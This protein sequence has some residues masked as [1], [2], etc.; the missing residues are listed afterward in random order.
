MA[1][2]EETA[3]VESLGDFIEEK[4][5]SEKIIPC[6]ISSDLALGGGIPF[7]CTI[8]VGGKQ[9]LG[10]TTWIL[11]AAANAQALYD[12]QI[13]YYNVEGRLT[14]LVTEQVRGIKKD[15][16]NVISPPAIYEK[17]IKVG[18]KKWSAEK[19]W[20]VI[21]ENIANN[22]ST[23][24]IVDSISSMSTEREIAEGVG[25][26]GRGDLQRLEASFSRLCGDIIVPSKIVLF[27]IAHIQANTSG[28]GASIQMNAGN[29]LKHLADVIMFGKWAEEW[30]PDAEEG[31][32]LGHDCHFALLA[33]SGGAPKKDFV[34]PLRYGYGIDDIKDIIEHGSNLDIIQKAGSW[35]TLPFHEGKGGIEYIALDQAKEE[36]KLLKFQGEQKLWNWLKDHPDQAGEIEKQIRVMLF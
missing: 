36:K 32:A 12:T 5:R 11:Q 35:F 30:K 17:D 25:Y 3:Y 24:H 33:S 22:P 9:K 7:G 29:K 15:I 23:I 10:K 4:D 21:R 13:F 14:K 8:L 19:W 31:D 27:L 34:V 2:E 16:W 26:Q 20:T 18:H 6:G 1:K 28:M